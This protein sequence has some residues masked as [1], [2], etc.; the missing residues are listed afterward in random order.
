MFCS[1]F[2]SLVLLQSSFWCLSLSLGLCLPGG[3]YGVKISAQRNDNKNDHE[4]VKNTDSPPS[5]NS[6][7][8]L[9]MRMI[10]DMTQCHQ[11]SAMLDLYDRDN[12]VK[13]VVNLLLVMTSRAGYRSQ[14]Q[15]TKSNG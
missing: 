2:L 15:T 13:D 11:D 14:K 10:F 6:A 4:S 3:D 7:L 8:K 1:V 12:D 9:K 5:Q